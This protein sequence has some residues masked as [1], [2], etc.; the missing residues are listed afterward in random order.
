MQRL[1]L[2]VVVLLL[3]TTDLAVAAPCSGNL[4]ASVGAVTRFQSGAF[5]HVAR[6]VARNGPLAVLELMRL[7]TAFQD[8]PYSYYSVD[9]GFL[10][11]GEL[12]D[13]LPKVA[14][15]PTP[16]SDRPVLNEDLLNQI[17]EALGRWSEPQ[18][19]A[20]IRGVIPLEGSD[21]RE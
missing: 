5:R 15:T 18:A 13:F 11:V 21:P 1:S 10:G 20:T 2:S 4:Q 19:G 3:L 8:G 17:A 9:Y 12:K 7:D 16:I 6:I 14:A